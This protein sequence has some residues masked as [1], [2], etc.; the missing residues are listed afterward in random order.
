MDGGSDK[1]KFSDLLETATDLLQDGVDSSSSSPS[2]ND[3]FT[4][5]EYDYDAPYNKPAETPG[6][7]V[8]RRLDGEKGRGDPLEAGRGTLEGGRGSREGGRG[9]LSTLNVSD[10]DLSGITSP[11]GNHTLLAHCQLSVV[12]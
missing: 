5:S 2:E 8:F 9:S 7:M 10:D 6:G 3:S 11:S 1:K 12:H 4:C